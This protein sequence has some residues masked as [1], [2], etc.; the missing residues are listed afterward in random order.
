MWCHDI[1]EPEYC[2]RLVSL[3]PESVPA[4]QIPGQGHGQP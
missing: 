3:S 2:E 4:G 1:A